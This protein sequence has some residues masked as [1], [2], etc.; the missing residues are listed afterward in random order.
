MAIFALTVF[1][2]FEDERIEP[3]AHPTD[4]TILIEQLGALVEI[5]RMSKYLSGS[6]R[7]RLAITDRGDNVRLCRED[8]LGRR[9]VENHRFTAWKSCNDI[10][11]AAHR[12]D[13]TP[14]MLI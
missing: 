14:Q 11:A 9:K 1:A 5:V 13:V 8:V 3:P 10:K 6:R 12:L 7:C 4:G 2:S